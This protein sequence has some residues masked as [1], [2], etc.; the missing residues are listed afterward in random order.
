M[1]GGT[2]C[3]CWAPKG[4]LR[5]PAAPLAS[6]CR[7][8]SQLASRPSL[9]LPGP[10]RWLFPQLA[11]TSLLL[12]AHTPSICANADVGATYSLLCRALPAAAVGGDCSSPAVTQQLCR[13]WQPAVVL[14]MLALAGHHAF[15]TELRQRA[16]FL[17]QRLGQAGGRAPD[18]ALPS[19]APGSNGPPAAAAPCGRRLGAGGRC[20]SGGAACLADFWLSFLTPAACCLFSFACAAGWQ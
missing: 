4:S 15:A 12:L 17:A 16:A 1:R 13:A 2:A 11:A 10:C 6:R 3:G 20:G 7:D 18:A 9:R 14:L 19:I 8:A 5:W